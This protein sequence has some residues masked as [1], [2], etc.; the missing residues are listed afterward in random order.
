M[1][2]L[3][4]G[5][6]NFKKDGFINVDYLWSSKPDLIYD[7]NIFPY[8]FR[9][10]EFSQIDADHVLE[11]LEDPFR[12]MNEIH[13]LGIDGARV[14]IR[15]PHF[16][17]GFTHADHKRGFDVTFPFYFD[18]NFQ[19]GYQGVTFI[20]EGVS[21]KWFAQHNLKR[22]IMPWS[23]FYVARIVGSLLDIFANLSPFWCSRIWCYWVGGF[24]E[25]EFRFRIIK[26]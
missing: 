8:P 1:S 25:I 20:A 5:S 14:N 15:V 12:V 10:N 4:L 9:E 23:V 17:R 6:G 18:S 21:L 13:R 16:S 24:D 22:S 19:G 2:K 26:K 3:N 7:L 11:H